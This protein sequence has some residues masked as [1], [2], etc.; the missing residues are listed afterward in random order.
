M[1]KIG[2][3]DD[4]FRKILQFFK[5]SWQ[6]YRR[7]RKGVKRRLAKHMVACGCRSVE[8][9]LQFLE[10]NG[11]ANR[12]A[13]ELLTVSI[14]RFFRDIRLWEVME[15]CVIPKIVES[16]ENPGTETVHAWSA[17]CSCGEEVYS[18]K[19]LWHSVRQKNPHLPPLKILATDSNPEVLRKAQQG[20]YPQSSLKNL[21]P[22]AVNEAFVKAGRGFALCDQFKDRIDWKLH[23]FMGEPPPP[24]SFHM[25]FLRN[26]LLT[27]YEPPLQTHSLLAILSTL[28]PEGFLIIGQNESLSPE[29]EFLHTCQACKCIFQRSTRHTP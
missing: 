27:Y 11:N 20:V 26:N 14:S 1:E 22:H 28:R 18:L 12:M 4:S 13:R 10:K 25:I 24:Q 21:S 9:Y 17:G 3:D 6:G 29:A 2:L 16:M 7:V 23:D 15:N 5:L 19:I 8:D